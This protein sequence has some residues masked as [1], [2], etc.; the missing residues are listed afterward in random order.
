MTLLA[1]LV[2]DFIAHQPGV[3]GAAIRAHFSPRLSK[4]PV[5]EALGWL[6]ANGKVRL[7]KQGRRPNGKLWPA[8]FYAVEVDLKTKIAQ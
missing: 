1:R 5:N 4:E 3:D 7:E 6:H 2:F 8:K